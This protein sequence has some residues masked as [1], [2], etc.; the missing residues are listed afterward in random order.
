[1]KMRFGQKKPGCCP[2]CACEQGNSHKGGCDIECCPECGGQR[3][4]CGHITD[5]PDLPWTGEFPGIAEAREFGLFCYWD[6]HWLVCSADHPQA[7]PDLNSLYSLCT[8][9]KESR[10]WKMTK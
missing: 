7:Q 3:L 5:L 8:W 10:T 9:D 6:K 1:V 2:D 4:T